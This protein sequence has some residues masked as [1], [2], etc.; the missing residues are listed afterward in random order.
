M[1]E[2]M[3]NTQF[4]EKFDVRGILGGMLGGTAK[5]GHE[6]AIDKQ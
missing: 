2:G 3:F 5:K 4:Y 6:E 1:E